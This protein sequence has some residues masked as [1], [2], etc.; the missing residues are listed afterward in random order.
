M[1]DF[2]NVEFTDVLLELGRVQM[3]L[4]LPEIYIFTSS[5]KGNYH[6]YCLRRSTW[7]AMLFTLASTKGID[8]QFFKLGIMRGYMTLRF[9]DKIDS[10][11]SYRH[12]IL[13]SWQNEVTWSELQNF[14]RYWTVRR[15]HAR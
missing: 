3:E 6:A 14:E 5:R 15:K 7:A 10:R 9:S 4:S 13:S 8:Q 11:I 2:D 12:T 1:W